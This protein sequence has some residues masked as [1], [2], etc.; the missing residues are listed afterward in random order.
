MPKHSRCRS[1]ANSR[2]SYITMISSAQQ[3]VRNWSNHHPINYNSMTMR[4]N[5]GRNVSRITHKN[6]HKS[7]RRGIILFIVSEILFFVSFFWTFFHT[8]L[9]P[10]IELGSTWPPTGI[11]PFYPIQVP[12]LNTAI[13]LASGVSVTWAHEHISTSR[14]SAAMLIHD[15]LCFGI[16]NIWG[17][18]GFGFSRRWL[19][20]LVSYG[21]WRV[22]WYI[23]IYV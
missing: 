19:W 12:L 2:T 1:V 14:P 11:Q 5:P 20:R 13:R 4:R 9:P 7:L 15:T 18:W 23:S 16:P 22:A 17:R 3:P 8:R 10:T 6:N 21:M